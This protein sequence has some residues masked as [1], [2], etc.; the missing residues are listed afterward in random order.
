[1]SGGILP[2]T[3][4]NP[5]LLKLKHPEAKDT[6]QKALLQGP[7]QK[8]LPIVYDGIDEELIKKAAIRTKGSS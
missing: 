3:D 2:M 1:M 8:M 7:I 6:S 5:Q 4:E